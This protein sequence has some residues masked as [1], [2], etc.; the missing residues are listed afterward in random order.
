MSSKLTLDERNSN[1]VRFYLTPYLMRIHDTM[2]YIDRDKIPGISKVII[3]TLRYDINVFKT[4]YA[5]IKAKIHSNHILQLLAA[6]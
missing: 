4:A 6:E 1:S 3:S 2:W 5:Y